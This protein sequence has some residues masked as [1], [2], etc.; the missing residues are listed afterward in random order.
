MLQHRNNLK[1]E[2]TIMEK[3]NTVKQ[4][5]EEL[6]TTRAL[7]TN[8]TNQLDKKEAEAA[9]KKNHNFVQ[10]Y[11]D[12]LLQLRKLTHKNKTALSVLLLLVEKMDK[13]NAL[14]ISQNT[15]MKILGKS[16]QTISK[17][18][19]VLKEGN[20]IN[21]VKV[22]TANAYIINANVFW[23]NSQIMKDRTATFTATVFAVKNEQEENYNENWKGVKL[24]RLPIFNSK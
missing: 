5:Q 17:S 13:Q 18:I 23:Q 20:F 22:G 24:D 16:R 2:E 19:K 10:L 8:L 21:I 14:I 7:N 1:K 3:N 12:Q 4:L 6:K 15:L 9:Y 11:R